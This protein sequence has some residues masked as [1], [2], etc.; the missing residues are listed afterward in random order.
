MNLERTILTVLSDLDGHLT[1]T[2]AVHSHV[3]LSTGK[4][5][6]LGDVRAALESLERKGQVVGIDHE[7]YGHR[8]KITDAGKVR[9]RE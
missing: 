4:P 3:G 5:E 2:G 1:T 8:W 7:D 9:L 6:T